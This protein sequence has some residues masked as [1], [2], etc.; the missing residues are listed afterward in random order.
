MQPYHGCSWEP[1]PKESRMFSCP[2]CLHLPFPVL[3]KRSPSMKTYRCMLSITLP[4]HRKMTVT[5][6][7]WQQQNPALAG[8]DLE[9]SDASQGPGMS[10]NSGPGCPRFFLLSF[11]T[12]K[13]SLTEN[14]AGW[15]TRISAW[16][17]QTEAHPLS[18][19]S[20]DGRRQRK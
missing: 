19:K 15:L 16:R 12:W 18:E 6:L 4:F 2:V 5:F 9:V 3:V 20:M 11:S 14:R 10:A 17:S 1:G 13:S 7:S 8:S